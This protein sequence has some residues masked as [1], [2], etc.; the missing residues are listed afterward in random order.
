MP[1]NLMTFLGRAEVWIGLAAVGA[2]LV[3]FWTLRGA[4]PGL[5][6]G[7]DDEEGAPASAYRDRVIAGV[8]TGL[9]LILLGAALAM[10]RGVLW[11]LPVFA[12]GL[13][14]VAT[15][16]VVNERYRHVSPALR[17]TVAIS[18]AVL[19]TGLVAGLLIVANVMA[20]RYGGREIDLTRE[21]AYSLSSLSRNQAES[22][23]RPVTFHLVHGRSA[24]A[25]RQFDR[26]WQLLELYRA[27]R[28]DLVRVERLDRYAELSR[29]DDLARR[30][31]ELAV[32]Q[33]GGVLIEYGEGDAARFAAISNPEMFD[34]TPADARGAGAG[35]YESA[36][37]GE[38]AVTSALIRLRE[39][40]TAKV[41]F[42]VGHGESGSDR[43]RGDGPGVSAWKARLA[44]VGCEVVELNLLEQAVP[45]EIE[46]VILAGP[47]EPFKPQELARLRAYADRGKPVL[48]CLGAAGAAGLDDFLKSF[49]LEL[50]RR[51]LVDPRL[52]LNGQVRFVFC[53]VEPGLRHPVVDGLGTERAV[54]M[55]DGA[56]IHFVGTKGAA[57]EDPASVNPRMLPSPILRS[58]PGSWAESQADDPQPKFN[59]EADEPGPVVVAAAVVQRPEPTPG[60]GAIPP[61]PRLVLISSRAAG[62]DA[63]QALEPTNLDLLMNA[64][65]WLR[66]REDS[67]G[68][69]PK[70]H[71]ALTLTAD[72]GL[73]WRLTLVPT[74]VSM[75]GVAAIGLLVYYVRQE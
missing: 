44:A 18:R 69:P 68:V 32:M 73:R 24:L 71:A 55:V 64:A 58:G 74:V 66:G 56:P 40:K 31:P 37:K 62:D 28:P 17:R 51:T 50:G 14:L 65:S 75:A 27:V 8:A 25:R 72:P 54:L 2:F 23:D 35:R 11:S 4:P 12:L 45:E 61:T 70:I 53:L 59:R 60:A 33:G 38:D 43:M 34:Q 42:T 39:G 22:L 26:V 1:S 48:A 57:D 46:L 16:I 15:L 3:L 19:N 52:N 63:V 41:A 6:A 47:R 7:K 36:F 13:G 49:N 10:T 20:F 9:L 30:A 67:V 29:A 5:S 21:R